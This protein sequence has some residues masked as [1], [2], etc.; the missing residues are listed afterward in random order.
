MNQ[1]EMAGYSAFSNTQPAETRQPGKGWGRRRTAREK[2][3]TGAML[4]DG[5]SWC[6]G[7]ASVGRSVVNLCVN[8]SMG[9]AGDIWGCCGIRDGSCKRSLLNFS[10]K[11]IQPLGTDLTT[12]N[13]WRI[14]HSESQDQ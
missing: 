8:S 1:Q 10:G 13:L 2:F 9:R 3:S 7:S 6:H 4:P 14:D 11:Q 12:V 5:D